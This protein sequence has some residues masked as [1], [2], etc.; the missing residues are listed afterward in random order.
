MTLPGKPTHRKCPF[1]K[2][3][4]HGFPAGGCLLEPMSENVNPPHMMGFTES[5]Y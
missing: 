4:Q 5:M 3:F 1:H 2:G